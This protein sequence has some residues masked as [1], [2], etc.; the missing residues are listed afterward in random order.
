MSRYCPKYCPDCGGFVVMIK[1]YRK[2]ANINVPIC[3]KCE[4]EMKY[5]CST[6]QWDGPE[7]EEWA[8]GS[9]VLS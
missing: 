8:D 5:K 9:K 6:N 7:W 3:S 2:G 1:Q 4:K